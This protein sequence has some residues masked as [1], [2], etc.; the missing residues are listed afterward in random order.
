MVAMQ[1]VSFGADTTLLQM[2][3]LYDAIHLQIHVFQ[4]LLKYIS[5]SSNFLF[6]ILYTDAVKLKYVLYIVQY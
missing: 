5:L 2:R 1:I 3:Q 6:F 4:F